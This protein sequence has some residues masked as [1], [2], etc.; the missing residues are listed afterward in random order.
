LAS[1]KK[2]YRKEQPRISPKK[3]KEGKNSPEPTKSNSLGTTE[4]ER[5]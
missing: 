5:E 1:A 4:R 3:K 2:E